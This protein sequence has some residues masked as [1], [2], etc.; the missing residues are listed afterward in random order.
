M[1]Q[2]SIKRRKIKTVQKLVREYKGNDQTSNLKLSKSFYSLAEFYNNQIK[3]IEKRHERRIIIKLGLAHNKLI[4]SEFD[5]DNRI[6]ESEY[7]IKHKQTNDILKE[8]MKL[9]ELKIIKKEYTKEYDNTIRN[10]AVLNSLKKRTHNIISI[11]DDT[12]Y[13]PVI[14]NTDTIYKDVPFKSL[15]EMLASGKFYSIEPDNIQQLFQEIANRYADI[16]GSK[17]IPVLFVDKDNPASLGSYNS[18]GNFIAINDD[19]IR[20]FKQFARNNVHNKILP[21]K[22]LNT[23][24]HELVHQDQYTNTSSNMR[25]TYISNAMKINTHYMYRIYLPKHQYDDTMRSIYSYK[26]N[27]GDNSR[28]YNPQFHKYLRRIHE[29]DARE[30]STQ[31][32]LDLTNINTENRQ[33]ILDY[34]LFSMPEKYPNHNSTVYEMISLISNYG[35]TQQLAKSLYENMKILGLTRTKCLVKNPIKDSKLPDSE[36]IDY[37]KT[38]YKNFEHCNQINLQLALKK[39]TSLREKYFPTLFNQDSIILPYAIKADMT[40]DEYRQ[41]LNERLETDARQMKD[42]SII[43]GMYMDN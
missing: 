28:N 13:K 25:P 42:V 9:D 3:T 10:D 26:T 37:T 19:Y 12:T 6:R 35:L 7:K 34:A 22:L 21:Y 4:F 29:M 23:L 14:M 16:N 1:F 30:T 32:L 8:Q 5:L 43:E 2:D 31:M 18:F 41:D 40:V 24:L 27:N 17:R 20:I 33:E 11:L 38:V 15:I 39:E 36:T